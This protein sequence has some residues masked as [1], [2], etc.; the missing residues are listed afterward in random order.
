MEAYAK[1]KHGVCQFIVVTYHGKMSIHRHIFV[2]EKEDGHVDL[3]IREANGSPKRLGD[4]M[5]WRRDY[6]ETESKIQI[7]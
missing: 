5:F 2:E 3:I 7:T 1:L 6:F 4:E